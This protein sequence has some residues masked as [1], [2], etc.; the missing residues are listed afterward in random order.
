MTKLR[1]LALLAFYFSFTSTVLAR[2]D[3]APLP[4]KKNISTALQKTIEAK[5]NNLSADDLAQV[6]AAAKR[7]QQESVQIAKQANQ[8][9]TELDL[10]NQKM[11]ETAKKI[12]AGE[13]ELARRQQ[14]LEVLQNHLQESEKKFNAEHGI[15]VETLAALQTL[16]LRPSEAVLIQPLSPVEVMRSSILLRGSV[17]ALK[18]RA[19]I[20]RKGIEDINNQKTEIAE[21]QQTIEKENKILA[22]QQDEMES[23]SKQKSAMYHQLSAQSVEAKQKAQQLAG[24]AHDLRDLL[25]KLEKQKALEQQREL[26]RRQLAEKE[27]LAKQQAAD[28]LRQTNDHSAARAAYEQKDTS[29]L[30]KGSVAFSRAKGR[31]SRPARGPIITAFHQELSKGVVSNGIDIKTSA[32]AQIIAPYDGTV[33]FA[34]PF[35]NFATL[36]IID[37][38]EGYTSLL[39]GLNETYTE[40]GQVIL[41]GEPLGVMPNNN[42]TKLHMEIR[43]NNHPINPN[44]WISKN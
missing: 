40:V 16:A 12:Q 36:I 13:D 21:R 31:L 27:R 38:G 37:H 35:K 42:N 1:L 7:V 8:V 9:K 26:Q 32:K 11:R 2:V 23:L 6:E 34:G 24:Q 39:S 17:H 30:P 15:L 5:G 25:D 3:V 41:A 18:S 44:E 33:I 28:N 19:E 43:K 29:S 20:I 4:P 14:E 22:K 10:V